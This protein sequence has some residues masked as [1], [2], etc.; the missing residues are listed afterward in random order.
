MDITSYLLSK[1]YVEDSLEG[2]G[3]L[4]GKSAYDIAKD[5][6]FNGSETEWLA[7]L[8]GATPIIGPNGTWVVNNKDTGVIASPSLAG[9]ATEDYVNTQIANIPE[10]DLKAYATRQELNEALLGIKIPDVSNFATKDEVAEAISNIQI[11]Q[12]DLT[13]YALK[14]EIKGLATEEFVAQKIAEAEL[15]G[16]EADLSAFYTKSEIDV[17]FE[18]LEIPN[19]DLTGYATEDFV[20]QAI[21]NIQIPSTQ[22]LATEEFVTNAISNIKHPTVDLTPYAKKDELPSIQ[23]LATEGYVNTQIANLV[24]TAPETLDT[25]GE[26]A[27]A[28]QNHEDV[29][30]I[31]AESVGKKADKSELIG[32]ASESYVND[33]IA[34][35][36]IPEV[37]LSNY[38]TKEEIP[39]LEGYATE[40]YV[41]QKI[42]G[43]E[44]GSGQVAIEALSESEILAIIGSATGGAPVT[45][46]GQIL[47]AMTAEDVR[48]I[49]NT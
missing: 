47:Q 32:L 6:G 30:E 13:S 24:N 11:P 28:L 46:N 26:I 42:S 44:V 41:N 35:I 4:K 33:A 12:I 9:Y 45:P 1:K 21:N 48:E 3:A 49:V 5:N 43:I 40:A 22:G 18:N 34:K 36:Q 10:V 15:G 27:Q 23:G 29:A 31:L 38:A 17:K 8:V 25:I 7:S 14:S 19:P 2:A 20:E 16:E 37:D 39:S